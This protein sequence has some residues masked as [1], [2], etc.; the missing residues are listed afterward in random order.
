MQWHNLM[1]I[2]WEQPGWG[3]GE[4]KG[5]EIGG[6]LL[7]TFLPNPFLCLTG[8]HLF[9]S[10]A[11]SSPLLGCRPSLNISPPACGPGTVLLTLHHTPSCCM[12][13]VPNW[14]YSSV[15]MSPLLDTP[16]PMTHPPEFPAQGLFFFFFN[17]YTYTHKVTEPLILH[18]VF[19]GWLHG[20][21]AL[22]ALASSSSL[23]ACLQD[24]TSLRDLAHVASG[25]MWTYSW[26]EGHDYSNQT[27]AIHIQLCPAHWLD[28]GLV[29]LTRN[30]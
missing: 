17:M 14:S 28:S 22:L 24:W 26:S 16:V 10:N 1:S 5:F 19:R 4:V 11:I 15:D 8:F 30:C 27:Y 6:K 7:S 9:P 13:P 25:S 12:G 18:A 21:W 3:A 23:P 29:P 2:R 20:R